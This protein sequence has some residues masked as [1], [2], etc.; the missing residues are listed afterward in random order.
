MTA[1]CAGGRKFTELV[2]YHVFGHVN[3]DEFVSVMNGEGM[4]HEFGGYHGSAA[5]GLDDV[6]LAGSIHGCYLLLELHADEG[7][8]F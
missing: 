2:A 1:E 3:G 8:F 7:A 6:F 4:A 5:P